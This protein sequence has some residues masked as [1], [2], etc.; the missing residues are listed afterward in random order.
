MANILKRDKQTYIINSLAEGSS[1][2]SMPI[3]EQFNGKTVWSGVVEVFELID[4]D[5]AKICYAWGH[6]TEDKKSRYITVLEIPPIKSPIDAV[7][8]SIISDLK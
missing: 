1:I 2:K 7:R 5:K 8:A 4:C 3:K 6:H